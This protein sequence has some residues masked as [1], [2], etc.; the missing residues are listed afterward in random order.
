VRLRERWSHGT[1]FSPTLR[2]RSRVRIK[3]CSI[4]HCRHGLE[5][6]VI[7]RLSNEFAQVVESVEHGERG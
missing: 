6:D 5:C 1:T 4:H 7:D 2:Q 3:K